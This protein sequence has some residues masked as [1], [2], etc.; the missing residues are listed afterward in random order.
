MRDFD[1]AQIHV[2]EDLPGNHGCDHHHGPA[3]TDFVESRISSAHHH[4]HEGDQGQPMKA[5]YGCNHDHGQVM[6][7]SVEDDPEDHGRDDH[8]GPAMKD[9]DGHNY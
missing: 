1:P 7:H 4:G 2:L 9:T 8:Y 5:N 3:M 6:K